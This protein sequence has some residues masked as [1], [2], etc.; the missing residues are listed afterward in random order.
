V[1]ASQPK[2]RSPLLAVI[3]LAF[4]AVPGFALGVLAG[5]AW[6]DP[7]L[8]LGHLL[9]RSVDVPW[10]AV[11]EGPPDAG[12]PPVA[13]APTP[14]PAP[15]PQLPA[16]AAP[17]PTPAPQPAPKPEVTRLRPEVLSPG[18]RARFAVQVGAFSESAVAEGLVKRLRARGFSAYVAPSPKDAAARW[19]VRVGPLASRGEADQ[20]AAR[21]KA[22]EKLPTWVLDENAV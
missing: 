18:A 22:E 2:K 11:A 6:E 14:R 8:L 16:V 10:G 12:T 15:R 13:A 9:G 7:G 17:A 20:M 1:T 5:V 19:R 4:L 3:G 21:L